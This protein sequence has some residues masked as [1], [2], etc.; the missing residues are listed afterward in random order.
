M[1]F[2]ERNSADSNSS[3]WLATHSFGIRTCDHPELYHYAMGIKV[4][5][6]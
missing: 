5:H 4:N 1:S 3:K 6:D 2:E